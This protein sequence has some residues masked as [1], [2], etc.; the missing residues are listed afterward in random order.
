MQDEFLADFTSNSH[1]IAFNLTQVSSSLAECALSSA[2]PT[3]ALSRA[4]RRRSSAPTSRRSSLTSTSGCATSVIRKN[5]AG[6]CL[7][8]TSESLASAFVA[9]ARRGGAWRAR[10]LKNRSLT[11]GAQTAHRRHSE[12]GESTPEMIVTVLAPGSYELEL[13]FIGFVSDAE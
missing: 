4:P 7:R 5:H 8:R 10:R 11:C 12:L 3:L 13:D 2:V 6:E 9:L 1:V